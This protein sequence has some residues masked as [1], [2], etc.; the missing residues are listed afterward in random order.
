[1]TRLRPNY[2]L[3][4]LPVLCVLPRR[5]NC[6]APPWSCPV[7][8]EFSHP[9]PNN[10]E[11]LRRAPC[12]RWTLS[13][14][15]DQCKLCA[16]DI[17]AVN[18]SAIAA[19]ATE[20]LLGTMSRNLCPPSC[21]L[22]TFTPL[23]HRPNVTAVFLTHIWV[24]PDDRPF[25][26]AGFLVN[27]QATLTSLD[28]TQV[29]L[30]T[31]TRATF[32]GFVRLEALYLYSNRLSTIEVNAFT[33][34]GAASGSALP[35]LGRFSITFN[36]LTT[37]DWTVFKPLTSSLK[38][39]DLSSNHIQRIVLSR[40]DVMHGVKSVLLMF[41]QL[42]NVDDRF[43]HSV[44]APHD[45][46]DLML[47]DNPVCS[48]VPPCRRIRKIYGKLFECCTTASEPESAPDSHFDITTEE[49]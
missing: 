38:N 32:G 33:A 4:F 26:V 40:F 24:A 28:L 25:P 37:L 39:L 41:N 44:S 29:Y 13:G 6:L 45:R 9:S 31:I 43:L 34:V 11:L 36:N 48:F 22:D 35:S 42:T 15:S 21:L 17:P 1:M 19:N 27:V 20:I 8:E 30:P 2:Y 7:P 3:L 10:E 18:L 14:C 5:V 49:Y 12:E 23:P 16:C 46:P 47:C